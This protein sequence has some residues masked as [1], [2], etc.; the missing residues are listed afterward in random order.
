MA[1]I[2]LVAGVLVT[3]RCATLRTDDGWLTAADAQGPRE[4]GGGLSEAPA[5]LREV[6][7]TSSAAIKRAN[8]IV[9]SL[10]DRG[11]QS[12]NG[13]EASSFFSSSSSTSSSSFSSS[14]GGGGGKGG[15]KG[16]GVPAKY[17]QTL[18]N[19]GNTLFTGS[20]KLG[21]PAQ[22]FQVVYDTGSFELLPVFS[23]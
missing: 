3:I 2:A 4:E 11:M 6:S 21:T 20:M 18:T 14:S 19:H 23:M 9:P 5:D 10:I 13:G 1:R 22:E 15:G 8:S 17:R 16:R 12:V 7:V